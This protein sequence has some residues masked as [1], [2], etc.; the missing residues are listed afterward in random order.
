MVVEQLDHPVQTYRVYHPAEQ[1][2]KVRA[3][4]PDVTA[5]PVLGILG[6]KSVSGVGQTELTSHL[7]AQCKLPLFLLAPPSGYHFCP[8]IL[9]FKTI[10]SIILSVGVTVGRNHQY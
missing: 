9:H 1:G 4:C 10:I 3:W 2:K 8:S 5:W 7:L 6:L